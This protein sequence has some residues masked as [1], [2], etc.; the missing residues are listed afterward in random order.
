MGSMAR[1]MKNEIATAPK[2]KNC[3]QFRDMRI[4]RLRDIE[5]GSELNESPR[6]SVDLVDLL[7]LCAKEPARIQPLG[8]FSRLSLKV[9]EK[10]LQE[11]VSCGL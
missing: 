2:K 6:P 11:N 4:S 3:P 5:T 8:F 1:E 7:S 9:R 10:L